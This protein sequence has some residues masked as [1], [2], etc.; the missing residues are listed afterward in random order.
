MAIKNVVISNGIYRH[1]TK[2]VVPTTTIAAQKVS[3]YQIDCGF[4]KNLV[5]FDKYLNVRLS[6]RS[7]RFKLLGKSKADYF[8]LLDFFRR[9]I[10]GLTGQFLTNFYSLFITACLVACV[11]CVFFMFHQTPGS[12]LVIDHYTSETC[13]IY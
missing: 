11:G 13:G 5:G 9:S 6:I 1:K 2:P 10:I 7:L 8:L 4:V 3:S 12:Y